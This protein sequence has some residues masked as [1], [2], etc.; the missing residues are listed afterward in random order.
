MP[1]TAGFSRTFC[2]KW[3]LQSSAPELAST[4][5]LFVSLTLH[6]AQRKHSLWYGLPFAAARSAA[7]TVLLQI[8]HFS[9][10][11]PPNEVVRL[12][13]LG[14]SF[15]ATAPAPYSSA[16]ALGPLGSSGTFSVYGLIT[17]DIEA[18][19]PCRSGAAVKSESVSQSSSPMFRVGLSAARSQVPRDSRAP[20]T[21]RTDDHAGGVATGVFAP[22]APRR[23]T[24]S[25]NKNHR[26]APTSD[27]KRDLSRV[28]CSGKSLG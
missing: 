16:R 5:K 26:G 24:R 22:A 17:P 18:P 4:Q 1:A 2:I 15:S 12:T 11:P 27:R 6:V 28:P 20:I 8:V 14:I 23:T 9:P 3:G 13:T 25:R 21:D 19:C 7:Y 10:P